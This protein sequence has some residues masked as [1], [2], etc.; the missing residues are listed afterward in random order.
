[1]K[2]LLKDVYYNTWLSLLDVR[3]KQAF[4]KI[5]VREWTP[6][7]FKFATAVS[8]MSSSRIEG[9]TLEVDSYIK[10]K[11]M[12]IEYLPGLTEKPNDLY[13]AY[14][15]AKDHKLSKLNF[16]KTH[17]IAT[18][19]LLPESLRGEIRKSNMLIMEPRAQRVEY[20][21]ASAQIVQKEYD[22]FW[23]ELDFLLDTEL[24]FEEIF[25][26]A[27]LV[28]LVFVK[29]HPFSDGNG[30]TARLLEKWFLASKLG[31]NAWYIPSEL[32][33]YKNLKTYYH[34]L[35]QIGLFYEDLKYEKGIPFLLMLPQSLILDE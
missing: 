34:H 10:H 35:A 3:L 5:Q 2:R 27:A 19:H 28:H 31:K 14:E 33:Y 22:T 17:S 26:Y 16:H 9:E 23:D 11:M 24:N 13:A 30:R 15:F 21:A 6:E 20:E 25:Y 18:K 29:I 7:N 4:E 1:M 8:V 32:Y 12:N